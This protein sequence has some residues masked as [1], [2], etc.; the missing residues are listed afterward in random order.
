[1]G[2]N[3]SGHNEK[4]QRSA[5]VK[6]I[7]TTTL[8]VERVTWFDELEFCNK[9]SEQEEL[10]PYYELKFPVRHEEGG[11]TVADVQVLGGMGY[12]LPTEAEWEYACRAGTTTPFS[13]PFDYGTLGQYGW[14][15]YIDR[16]HAVGER[17]PNAFG[18]CDMHGN[19][20]EWCYDWFG[21]YAADSV[22]DPTGPSTGTEAAWRVAGRTTIS[23]N[24][25]VRLVRKT[26]TG[27]RL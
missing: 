26:T 14:F 16:T 24:M 11:I 10:A 9:L 18:L 5:Q 20:H 6:E 3:V 15:G 4:G 8:P 25:P 22:L 17:K 12:R 13:F 27:L 23:C 1:M 21:P 7:D 2:R 19:V